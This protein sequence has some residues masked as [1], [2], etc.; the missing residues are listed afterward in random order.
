MIGAFVAESLASYAISKGLDRVFKNKKTFKK[1]LAKVIDKTINEFSREHP[2]ADEGERFAFYKSQVM[3]DELLKFRLFGHG[4]N[5]IDDNTI[6]NELKKNPNIL[7]PD[8]EDILAF[9]DI[10]DKNIKADKELKD[11]ALDENYKGGNF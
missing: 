11:L 6:V 9:L 3:V 2:I 1:R 10:F 4:K 7:R 8:K 5:R